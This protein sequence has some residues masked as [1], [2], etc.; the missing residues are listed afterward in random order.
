MSDGFQTLNP[1]EII[2]ENVVCDLCHS[3]Q[4]TP[5]HQFSWMGYQGHF[6][7]CTSCGL[8]YQ[9]PRPVAESRFKLFQSLEYW[10]H[11]QAQKQRSR[12]FLNYNS[13]LGES[14]WRKRTSQIRLKW[15]TPHIPKGARVLDIG[16]ADGQFADTLAQ[17]GFDASGM[18][19]SLPMIE[20]G[21]KR[22]DVNLIHGALEGDWPDCGQFDAI[23]CIAS[24]S[25]FSSPKAVFANV[26]KHLKKGGIFFFNYGD[27]DR[28]LSRMFG[29]RYPYFRLSATYLYTS[30]T[31][32]KY[33]TQAGLDLRMKWTDM[34]VIPIIRPFKD[35]G[36]PKTAQFMSAIGLD[37]TMI[38]VPIPIGYF[39]YAIIA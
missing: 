11:Q 16:C 32:Q 2:N 14:E 3:D 26:Q 34:Q 7:K 17:G 19:I 21:R 28:V 30:E 36:F 33:C 27:Y 12:D 29:A 23:T 13:Y 20:A 22:Y 25:T 5:V 31:I 37:Q 24:L 10:N 6:V 18:D 15:I 39:A 8:I 9:N 35:L 1:A 4:T 38:K